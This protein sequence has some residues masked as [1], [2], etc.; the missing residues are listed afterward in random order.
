V[1][2]W[3]IASYQLPCPSVRHTPTK[4]R[5]VQEQFRC[6]N[7]IRS[8]DSSAVLEFRRGD[9]HS[10]ICILTRHQP[11]RAEAPT[12]G[13]ATLMQFKTHSP[14]KALSPFFLLFGALQLSGGTTEHMAT[15]GLKGITFVEIHV[16]CDRNRAVPNLDQIE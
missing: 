15:E 3:L 7:G 5:C 13:N 4:G 2:P 16:M 1:R 8:S 6:Q 9:Y 14:G 12:I 10:Q 11:G